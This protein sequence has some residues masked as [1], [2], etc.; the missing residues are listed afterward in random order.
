MLEAIKYAREGKNEN[1]RVDEAALRAALQNLKKLVAAMPAEVAS[2][3]AEK[4]RNVAA[5]DDDEEPIAPKSMSRLFSEMTQFFER[6]DEDD[7]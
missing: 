5:F 2:E 4:V 3:F 6:L 1:I 7:E